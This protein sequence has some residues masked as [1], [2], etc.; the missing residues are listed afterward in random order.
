[1]HLFLPMKRGGWYL[2]GVGVE[3]NSVEG[4][5]GRVGETRL[6]TSN[7]HTIT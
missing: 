6:S 1:M 2:C 5:V 3:N 7:P 4:M